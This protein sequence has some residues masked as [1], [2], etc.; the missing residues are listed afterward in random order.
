MPPKIIQPRGMNSE[1]T[2][3]VEVKRTSI[4]GRWESATELK[5]IDLENNNEDYFETFT[6]TRK[7]VLEMVLLAC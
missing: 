3:R 7:L 4:V 1:P 2:K 5:G 6:V